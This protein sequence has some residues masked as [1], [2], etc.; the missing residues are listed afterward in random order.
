MQR[1]YT[2]VLFVLYLVYSASISFADSTHQFS[3]NLSSSDVE[4]DQMSE[5]NSHNL[6]ATAYLVP[7]KKS[8]SLPYE[9]S[10]FYTRTGSIS[11]STTRTKWK[12]LNSILGGRVLKKANSKQY[13]I[14]TFLAYKNMPIWADISYQYLDVMNFSFSDGSEENFESEFKPVQAISLGAYLDNNLSFYA[15]YSKQENETYG[16]GM[17]QLFNL[18]S[19]GF[20]EAR[21]ELSK[22]DRKHTEILLRKNIDFH[23]IRLTMDEKVGLFK[24][25]Y[26]PITTTSFNLAYQQIGFDVDHLKSHYYSAE[27]NHYL[28]DTLQVGI[29]YNHKDDYT[30]NWYQSGDYD[31][32]SL[33]LGFDF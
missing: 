32:I 14:N 17:V 9:K 1:T 2:K 3:V 18:S 15:S 12:G 28:T 23:I 13:S 10:A 22:T 19:F 30:S 5:V 20:L 24:F 26:F 33:N 6:E 31:A 7:V 25:S 16:V 29:H 8:D 27:I 21:I 4:Y 11:I